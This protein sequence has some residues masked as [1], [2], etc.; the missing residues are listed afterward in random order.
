MIPALRAGQ[1]FEFSG[2]GR[3]MVYQQ[4][5]SGSNS[6]G[7]EE[8]SAPYSPDP[9]AISVQIYIYS[10][11]AGTLGIDVLMS[12]ASWRQ[13]HSASITSNQL[14]VVNLNWAPPRVRARFTP[15]AGTGALVVDAGCS[16]VR[17]LS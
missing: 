12:D 8:A 11:D 13:V 1:A 3:R 16:G 7:V 4:I 5:L 17:S 15:S 10:A 2:V 14:L 9:S 6:A